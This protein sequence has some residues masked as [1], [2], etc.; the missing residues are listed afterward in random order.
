MFSKH[1]YPSNN[2]VIYT[3]VIILPSDASSCPGSYTYSLNGEICY[4]FVKE[5]KTSAGAQSACIALG[6]ILAEPKTEEQ[7][8]FL[9]RILYEHPGTSVWL[10]ATDLISEGSWYWATS[11]TPVSDGFTY[12]SPGQPSDG[13]VFHS[14][15]CMVFDNALRHWNDINCYNYKLSFICQKDATMDVVG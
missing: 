4:A 15:D 1:T 14:Q 6:G 5:A 2:R 11:N 13:G 9:E 10:G 7:N 3:N 8:G 12:W